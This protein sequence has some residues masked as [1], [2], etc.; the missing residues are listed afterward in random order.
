ML[1]SDSS[2]TTLFNIAWRQMHLV[3]VDG[4]REDTYEAVQ[5]LK[6]LIEVDL[7]PSGEHHQEAGAD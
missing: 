1:L 2:I 6:R 5:I 3:V 7:L 4:Q